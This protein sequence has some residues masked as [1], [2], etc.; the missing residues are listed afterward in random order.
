[1]TYRV[2]LCLIHTC[3]SPEPSDVRLVG[4]GSRCA[5]TIKLNHQGEWRHLHCR[6]DYPKRTAAV[7]CR[8]LGCGSAVSMRRVSSG[9]DRPVWR[10]MSYCFGSESALREC[11]PVEDTSPSKFSWKAVCSG[12][13][14]IMSLHS[15]DITHFLVYICLEL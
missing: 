9:E 13:T 10:F 4:G 7:A 15:A 8:Q 3:L 5:G 12:N 6:D 1:M 14:H 2:W 11:G